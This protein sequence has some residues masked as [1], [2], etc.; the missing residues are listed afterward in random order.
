VPFPPGTPPQKQMH[1]EQ[2]PLRRSLV[3]LL[4]LLL[5]LACIP[6]AEAQ[7]NTTIDQTIW[8]MLN[9]VTPAQMSSTAWLAADDDGDGQS[10]WNE[11][12]AGTNPFSAASTFGLTS[13]TTGTAG[14]TFTFPTVA[15]KLYTLQSSMTLSGSQSWSDFTPEVQVEGT[16]GPMMLP[17]PRPVSFIRSPCR[18]LIAWAMESAIGQ[19]ISPALTR[20]PPALATRPPSKA[21]W[22]WKMS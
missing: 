15:G 13:I 1:R 7:I 2:L 22:R 5:A 17:H 19:G 6:R 11:M 4:C 20:S 16:G 14:F 12:L 8:T 18:T 21:I 9:G 10:N 3:P